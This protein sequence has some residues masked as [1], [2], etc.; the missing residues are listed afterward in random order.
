MDPTNWGMVILIVIGYIG[1]IIMAG[2]IDD[3]HA[4]CDEHSKK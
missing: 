4:K 1:F 3:E 2:A